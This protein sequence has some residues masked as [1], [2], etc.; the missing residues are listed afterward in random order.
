MAFPSTFA[1]LQSSVIQKA[2]LDT[3][4]DTSKVKDWINQ[5]YAQVCVETE[6]NTTAVTMTLTTGVESYTL[7]AGVSR[8]KQMV[9]GTAGG[10]T[11]GPPLILTTL[12]EILELRQSGGDSQTA[13]Y[14]TTHYTVAGLSQLELW[15]TPR[16]ADTLLVWIVSLPTP[17][18]AAGDVPILEEP[19]AS[20]LLEYG[21]LVQAGEFK[22]DPMTEQWESLYKEWTARYRNHLDKR[23]GVIPGQFHVWGDGWS[24]DDGY[25]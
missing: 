15:R 3:T 5:A 6:S 18:S 2:R 10:S 23:K 19:F 8:I 7:P 11:F 20:K 4:L 22:G 21:A 17:L 14:G 9:L 25:Y 24:G 1:D 12:D 13:L 16:G